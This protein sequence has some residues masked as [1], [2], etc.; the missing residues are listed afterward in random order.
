VLIRRAGLQKQGAGTPACYELR[1]ALL[2]LC[3]LKSAPWLGF[4]KCADIDP[5]RVRDAVK[6]FHL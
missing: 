1:C 5:A 3:D 2:S 4:L 6:V